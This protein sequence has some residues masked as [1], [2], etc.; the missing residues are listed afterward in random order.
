[1]SHQSGEIPRFNTN[2]GESV[3]PE[4]N[5]IN[6][7]DIRIESNKI[8]VNYQT[9][10]RPVRDDQEQ[11]FSGAS[12]DRRDSGLAGFWL[13]GVGLV[14]CYVFYIFRPAG[15]LKCSLGLQ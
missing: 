3:T 15:F 8:N 13:E 5:L 6:T 7:R 4:S 14:G 2:T 1:M 10:S 9:L 11:L 12:R